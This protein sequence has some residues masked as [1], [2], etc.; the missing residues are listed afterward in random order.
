MNGN[1]FGGRFSPLAQ[2]PI[3]VEQEIDGEPI[4]LFSKM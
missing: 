1:L 2:R 3:L 4:E